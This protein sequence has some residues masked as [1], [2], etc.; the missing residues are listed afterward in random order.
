MTEQEKRVA[1]AISQVVSTMMERTMIRVLEEDPFIS[2]EHHAMKPLYAALVPDEVFKG[3][4]FER[5]FVTLFGKLWESLAKVVA[6]ETH[7]HC[8]MG[9]TITGN[10]GSERLRRIQE[11]LN[12]L[13]SS[14]KSGQRQKPN[15]NQEIAYILKGGGEPI[16][17]SVTCDIF[18]FSQITG[19]SYAFELKGPL[20][21]SDQTKVSK[22]KI[23][24]LLSMEPPQVKGAYFAL[25]YNPHGQKK[26]YSWGFTRRWFNVQEDE[27]V[28]I[29]DEF[30]DMIGGVGT[31]ENF[32][33]E[34]NI[35]G[36]KYKERILREFLGLDSTSVDDGSSK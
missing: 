20:P 24:K 31:Y 18:I 30:W 36:K 33:K 25:P 12:R 32:I 9:Y 6:L 26:D 29:G 22:E 21:N 16:P 14:E 7:G 34:I 15:W 28:L 23:F 8:I 2:E 11:I 3:S 1:D 4:H 5:R 19:E 17:V 10:I 35:I 13:G 27:V